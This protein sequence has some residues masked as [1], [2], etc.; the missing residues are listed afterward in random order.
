MPS[1]P[2]TKQDTSMS[3]ELSIE[4]SHHEEQL[5]SLSFQED[6][7]SDEQEEELPSFL[8]QVDKSKRGWSYLIK[9]TFV[10]CS[11][12]I[13]DSFHLPEPQSITEGVFVWHKFRNFP[14]WPAL[15]SATTF[16]VFISYNSQCRSLPRSTKS[17]VAWFEKLELVLNFWSFNDLNIYLLKNYL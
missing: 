16:Q 14:F 17:A 13:L 11:H 9:I 4:L 15:V 5:P 2:T 1:T 7:E 10:L 3:S 8:M 6:E 12:C